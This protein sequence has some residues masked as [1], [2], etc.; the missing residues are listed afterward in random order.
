MTSASQIVRMQIVL[1][2]DVET[3]ARTTGHRD[4]KIVVQ[5]GSLLT[6]VAHAEVIATCLSAWH[7]AALNSAGLPHRLPIRSV[8][9]RGSDISAVISYDDRPPFTVARYTAQDSRVGRAYVE[10]S[11]GALL[12]ICHDRAALDAV[13]A[14]WKSA[15]ELARI[16]WG[17]PVD[18]WL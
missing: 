6:Y 15:A 3:F 9:E 5:V 10:V 17:R 7:E 16:V 14:A 11:L 13:H 4:P 2:G 1:T 12:F 8:A 18:L